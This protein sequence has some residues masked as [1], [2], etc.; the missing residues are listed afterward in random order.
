MGTTGSGKSSFISLCTLEDIPIIGHGLSS[1]TSSVR[2]HTMAHC[3]RQIHLI[4]TPG[5]D[6]SGRSDGEI[7]QELAFWLSEAHEQ[8]I[9]ISGLLYLHRITDTRL[10]G[11]AMR[12]LKAFKKLC[13]EETYNGIILVTTRW[14]EV[15][16]DQMKLA[17][18]REQELRI[19]SWSDVLKKGG[20][21]VSLTAGRADALKII[22]H[23]VIENL[24]LTLRLQRQ[25][26]D[27]EMALEE[28]DVGKVICESL[29]ERWRDARQATEPFEEAIKENTSPQR[30]TE[31][32]KL[33]R[34]A[35]SS[36]AS[37]VEYEEE[38]K[39][40]RAKLS[41]I[42]QKWE[43]NNKKE[44]EV[45]DEAA[46]SNEQKLANRMEKLSRIQCYRSRRR[47][48][49]SNA[50]R[51]SS[52]PGGSSVLEASLLEQIEELNRELEIL[53]AWKRQRLDKR[54]V[55]HSKRNAVF[56]VVGTGLALG[57]LIAAI[58]CTV[59]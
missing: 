36:C 26:V 48:L 6:D 37:A 40:M 28:T 47:A 59:M 24:Q 44:V 43:S 22:S 31:S 42:R 25:L 2:I 50:S 23:I 12:S 8:G 56:S 32:G 45:L 3:G 1:C 55:R 53:N 38:V 5:F 14:D 57:Q 49:S 13:G 41:E 35:L 4:D 52:T 39:P 51:S 11:S 18:Q 16:L 30:D 21:I 9:K 34:E 46:R 58:S 15:R 10:G 29:S 19:N 33:E 17:S 54:V 27:E 7:L 20:R